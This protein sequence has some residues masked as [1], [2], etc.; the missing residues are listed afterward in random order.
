MASHASWMENFPWTRLE[1]V[2]LPAIQKPMADLSRLRLL[3]PKKLREYL[4]DG[5]YGG[6]Y[7]RS[8]ADMDALWDVAVGETR[9]L[10]EKGWA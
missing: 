5:N 4:G 2:S 3:N 1:G 7:E 10:L 6:L 9:E 8:D